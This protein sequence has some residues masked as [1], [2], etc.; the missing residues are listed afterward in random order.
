MLG[1]ATHATHFFLT[2]FRNHHDG[3]AHNPGTTIDTAYTLLTNNRFFN[4]V[5]NVI[6]HS[7]YNTY[8]VHLSSNEDAI[9]SLGWIGNNS[10]TPVLSDPNVKR[11]LFR[12]K[13]WDSVTSTNDSGTNDQTGTRAQ[14]E[15]PRSP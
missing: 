4:L 1:D 11:T 10:G 15:R 2:F 8:Q 7:H 3:Y 6:G 9:Y 14:G 5:G 13:N 12:W